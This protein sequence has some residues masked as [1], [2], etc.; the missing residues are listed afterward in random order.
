[1]NNKY[2]NLL[3]YLYEYSDKPHRKE[4]VN[5]LFC[6]VLEPLVQN[7]KVEAVILLRIFDFEDKASYFKRLFFSKVQIYN[8]SN[9]PITKEH[10]NL[11]KNNIWNNTEFIVVL[12]GRYS[13]ALIWDYSQ[14]EIKD[15]SR[16]CLLY[17]SR[18]ILDIAKS[19]AENSK[20]DIQEYIKKYVPDRREN[21]ALN[22]SI[23]SI[24]SMLNAKNEEYIFNN[25]EKISLENDEDTIKTAQTVKDKAKF[26]SHEIKNH[27]S[28]INLY[29][30]IANKRFA[31]IKGDE[32]NI[33]S[34][35][36]ALKN[37]TSASENISYL[38]NDLRCMSEPF[39]SEINIKNLIEETVELCKLKTENSG[40]E[41]I[42]NELNN[43]I[44]TTDKVKVQCA[45]TN[46]IFNAIDA[47]AKKI[48]I[49]T[50]DK[51]I[52]IKNN[53]EEIPKNVQPRIFEE[54]FTT[55]EKGNGLGLSFCKAQLKS[56]NGDIN[57]ISSNKNETV[58]VINI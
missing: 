23:Q 17:N 9:I 33:K 14:S 54:N 50:K 47:H 15:S 37:I 34:I 51:K 46:I 42:I 31:K 7:Q 39:K 1:M 25:K 56:V 53:G 21:S 44:A 26:I 28:I 29:S 19:I 41:L 24:A 12:G 13:A 16:V 58:F 5:D 45:I 36:N 8:F 4:T 48:E 43:T 3:T 10:K 38:I 27:L 22:K 2:N 40:V 55:K 35:Q 30:A 20:E 49:N 57:L 11:E 52:Y 32:E 18:I 6:A